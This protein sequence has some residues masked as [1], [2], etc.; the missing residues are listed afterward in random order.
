VTPLS[1]RRDWQHTWKK[2]AQATWLEERRK[3]NDWRAVRVI[4]GTKL[5]DWLQQFPSVELWL[6]EKMGLPVQQIETPEQRWSLL[7]TIGDPPPMIP[8]VF[9]VNRDAA[10]AKL[11]EVF[12]GTAIQLKLDTHFPEQ[13]VDFVSAYV[14][15]MDQESRIDS[16]GRCLILSGVEAWNAITARHERHILVANFDLDQTRTKLLEEALSAGHAVIFGGRPGGIPHPNWQSIP[17]PKS[18]QIKKALEKAGYRE[19]RARI[20]AQRSGGNLSSLLR[21]LQNL[22]LMPGW[23]DG[24]S[25]AELAIAELLGCWT[26]SSEGDRAIA[27][28]LSGTSYGEWIGKMRDVALRPGTPLT[29]RDGVWNFVARYE[30]WYALGPRLFDDHLN[31]LRSAVVDVLRDPDPKFELPADERYAAALHGKALK[32]SRLV[33]KGLADSLALLG[34]HPK[35]L[36]SC[37]FG[38]AETSAI[39][40]VREILAGSGWLQWA[41]LND[42]LPLLAEAAPSEFLS[43]V[44]TALKSDSCPF[45]MV[46]AQE[47]SGLTGANYTTGLLWALET[48][49]WDAK[50]LTRAVMI[51]GELAARDPGGHWANRPAN[52]LTTILLPW[53]PQTCAPIEKRKA[54]LT[55]LFD[56]LPDVAWKL[57]LSLLP[58]SHQASSYTRRPAWREMITDHWSPGVTD[59]EYGQQIVMYAD[60]VIDAARDDP[61]K[62]AELIERLDNLPRPGYEKILEYLASDSTLSM[63]E[64]ARLPM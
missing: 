18:Y 17:S 41:S 14:A 38:K 4:D 3:R 33:R 35:A 46:F 19:E 57:L 23:A 49:A 63:S 26:D 13:M 39:L 58:N 34:S 59:R 1:G 32:H 11:K 53:L 62:L 48:L 2:A 37:S 21:C 8:D 24:T 16:A 64:A 22:S 28:R 9:L 30:G 12:A 55:T 50:H 45:D 51:L 43:A 42:L 31:N 47:G 52:S 7:R 40:A 60:L 15:A 5:I 29:Q 56:E 54:A 25:A 27:E 36:T 20:L 10:C 61:S 44:E 6:A